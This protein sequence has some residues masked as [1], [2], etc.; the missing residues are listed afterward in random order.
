MTISPSPPTCSVAGCVWRSLSGAGEIRQL[1]SSDWGLEELGMRTCS[2]LKWYVCMPEPHP[3]RACTH[4]FRPDRDAR[5]PAHPGPPMSGVPRLIKMDDWDTGAEF[6]IRTAGHNWPLWRHSDIRVKTWHLSLV[7]QFWQL[8][9]SVLEYGTA[10]L[11]ND[12]WSYCSET[13][14]W[15]GI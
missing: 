14:L 3:S 8:L 1:T 10:V 4:H 12:K 5:A 13:N 15:N 11:G 2:L 7:G 9:V 6:Q